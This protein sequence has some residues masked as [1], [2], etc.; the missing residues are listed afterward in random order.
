[1]HLCMC[2]CYTGARNDQAGTYF[3][4]GHS[5]VDV[6]EHETY[7]T[8]CTSY[9]YHIGLV[10]NNI[11]DSRCQKWVDSDS[12]SDSKLTKIGVGSRP[13]SNSGVGIAHLWLL[14][15]VGYQENTV[16]WPWPLTLTF[17][18]LDCVAGTLMWFVRIGYCIREL[19]EYSVHVLSFCNC[20]IANIFSL[21]RRL[22]HP[23]APRSL[24]I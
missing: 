12:D 16:Q 3:H 22:L 7:M 6:I 17:V 14:C 19:G 15:T 11:S 13:D 5:S 4:V 1:M 20:S 21:Q 23:S 10:F 8:T 2:E 9:V 18:I 24:K